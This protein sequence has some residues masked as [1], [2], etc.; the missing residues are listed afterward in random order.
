MNKISIFISTLFGLGYLTNFPGTVAS[1]ISL[2]FIWFL[3][4][5]YS[6]A[7]VFLFYFLCLFFSLFFVSRAVSQL[8][9]KDPKVIVIDE[10]IGQFTALL[11]CDENINNYALAFFLFRLFDISKPFPINIIDQGNNS[12]CIIFDDVLA[13]LFSGLIIFFLYSFIL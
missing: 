7:V 9:E 2:F 5:N 3:K 8:E 4:I 12:G 11:F 6:E 1:F 10:Y 13:G